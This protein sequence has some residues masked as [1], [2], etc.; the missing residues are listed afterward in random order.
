MEHL[1]SEL[2][3]LV[4]V[5][6]LWIVFFG[7]M[8]E[9]TTMIIATGI[10]CYLGMLSFGSAFLVAIL[11]AIA[12]DQLWYFLGKNY[13]L[14]LLDYFPSFKPRVAK[15]EESVQHKGALLSFSGRFIYGGAILFPMTLGIYKYEHKTFTLLDALGVML[16]GFLGIS[17]GY[18]LGTSAEILFGKLEK[19]WHLALIVA[20]IIFMAWVI[21]K[22]I[23]INQE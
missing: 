6:G 2:T 21:K 4:N 8:V 9:G 22:Y 10:L 11:G 1:L 16:W 7:M 5:Y 20:F 19:V 3:P 13:A 12:G 17:L 14:K 15:L 18:I 23:F